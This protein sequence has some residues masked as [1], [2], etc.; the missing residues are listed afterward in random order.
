MKII[1]ILGVLLMFYI[2]IAGMC[3]P[4]KPGILDCSPNK[5]N[6]GEELK[7]KV[8]GYNTNYDQSSGN[9]AFLKFDTVQI[10]AANKVLQ[11]DPTTLLAYFDI[12]KSIASNNKLAEAT[13]IVSNEVDGVS[14]LPSALVVKEATPSFDATPWVTDLRSQ[15]VLKDEM[16][17]PFRNILY[18]TIRNTFFHVAI[19]MSMMILLIGAFYNSIQYLRTREMKYDRKSYSLTTVSIVYGFI[20]LITGSVWAKFTWGTFWTSDIKLN[21]AAIAMLIYSA[22][23]ILRSS[24]EDLDNKYKISAIYNIF[25]FVALIPLIYIVPRL[26]DS[27]HPGN[28]GN[29]A[30]GGEDLDNTLRMVFYPAIFG[31]AFLGLWLSNLKERTMALEYYMNERDLN[32]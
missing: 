30:L 9:K 21:M 6:A 29:P 13:L 5:V 12:P 15:I 10:L 11:S 17:F 20:G 25:A 28:G 24:I 19:W 14:L 3:V 16:A 32:S 8:I 2:L 27:L 1:K 7:L 4:L 22:Y 18:E 26:T 31:L 23:W